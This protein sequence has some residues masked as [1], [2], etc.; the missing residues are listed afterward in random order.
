[1]KGRIALVTGGTGG[2]GTAI[3]RE[4]AEQ[5]V[6]VVAGYNQGGPNGERAKAWQLQQQ[7]EGFTFE[8]AYGD[9]SNYESSVA[10]IEA[11]ESSI[12]PIDIL[13][14]NAGITRDA[15]LKKMQPTQWIAVLRTNLDS[16]FNVSRAVIEGML[17]R[18]YGRI[19]SISSINGQKGQ[20]GQTNYAAAKAG[21]YGFTKSLAQEVAAKG[22]TVN[23]ISPGYVATDMVKKISADILQKIVANIPVGRLAE[24]VEIARAVAFLADDHA[25]FITGANLAINGGQYMS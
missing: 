24:P 11:I 20:F 8:I 14:N 7:K 4:L 21:I 3:C 18:G 1:M 10:M 13:V 12:G 17:A 16:I 2:I 15:V 23:C 22:I 25:G 9:V 19:V 5:G 6:R